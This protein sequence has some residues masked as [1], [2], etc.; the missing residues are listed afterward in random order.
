MVTER[1]ERRSAQLAEARR[2]LYRPDADEAARARYEALLAAAPV[3]VAGSVR[4]SDDGASTVDDRGTRST[5]AIATAL[6]LVLLGAAAAVLALI[7]LPPSATAVLPAGL[8]LAEALGRNRSALPA[9]WR[10]AAVS[11]AS[12]ELDGATPLSAPGRVLLVVRCPSSDRSFQ[13]VAGARTAYGACGRPVFIAL[14]DGS[15][16]VVTTRGVLPFSAALLVAD[17]G[18]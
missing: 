10:D 3:A 9:A 18:S 5:I 8:P 11:A 7:A 6:V 15:H 1:D 16:V 17:A 2:A 12:D 4:T 14:T 13:A